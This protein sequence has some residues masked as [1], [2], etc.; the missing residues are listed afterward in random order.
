MEE[1]AS[2][3]RVG[4]VCAILAHTL[5]GFFPVYWPYLKPIPPVSLV[6]HRVVW[7][8]LL[9]SILVPCL[10]A[11]GR[12]VSWA[13]FRKTLSSWRAAAL[14]AAAAAMLLINW[15]SFIWAVTGGN[16][17][18]AS[19]G[20]YINPLLSIL[21]GVVVLH[22]RLLTIQWAAIGVVS[23]G[24]VVMTIAG[25]G[26]P[27]ASIG[28]ATAF[29]TYGLLKKKAPLGSLS[30]LWLETA[31]MLG[32]ALAYL[33]FVD[34]LWEIEGRVYE[35]HQ[36]ALLFGGGLITIVPLA[37][38]AIAA[39]SVPLSTVGVLQYIGPTLQFLVGVLWMG[40]SF[41]LWR[42]IGFIF[43]WVGSGFYLLSLGRYPTLKSKVSA[44]S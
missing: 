38:F 30:G 12:E 22:E 34:D 33:W 7:S 26:L 23:F 31:I 27:W 18:Q 17:L 40:E 24:V 42:A 16:V 36:W 2:R 5:W 8:F 43:V 35:T 32:P 15:L 25:G 9:L 10:I 13:T 4:Y 14:Y 19:L 21:L 11:V 44:D 39:K 29:A 41:G 20:Y 37:L 6:G 28:M 3:T 1:A